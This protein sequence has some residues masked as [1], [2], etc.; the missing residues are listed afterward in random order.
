MSKQLK[1]QKRDGKG[2]IL[3]ENEDQLKDGRYR[4]R[5]IDSSNVRR[6]V[7]SWKLVPTDKTPKG[8]RDDISLREKE[9]EIRQDLDDGIRI[10]EATMSVGA[11]ITRY[12]DSKPK[13]AYRTKTNYI[14]MF[15][16]NI[17]PYFRGRIVKDIRKSDILRYYAYLYKERKFSATTIQLYQNL[18]FPAFQMAV[19]DDIIRKNPCKGCMKDYAQGSM[20]SNRIPLTRGEQEELLQWVKSDKC[21]NTYYSILAFL[22]GTGC[23]ISE[24]VGMT[25]DD[26]DFQNKQISVNHQIIYGKKNGKHQFY[27]STPKNG[28][29]RIVPI[30]DDLLLILKRHKAETYLLSR[31]S[32]FEV[33]GYRNF[34]FINSGLKTHMQNTLVRA[35]HGIVER[36]NELAF[37][38]D[39]PVLL[40]DFSPHTLRHTYCTRMAEN[41]IDVKVLQDIM[42]HKNI[43]VTMQVYNHCDTER[44]HEAINKI[45]SALEQCVC[46]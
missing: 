5:Y 22:L 6:A 10:V 2:R 37:E 12:L 40:P 16:K 38:E 1:Q 46:I 42:G 35:F 21:Y 43:S 32:E 24:A 27:A 20:T 39:N 25:W 11:L 17:E 44:L 31:T 26:I 18:I 13:L 15:Q 30:K 9:K 28:T 45:P 3:R 8:K 23:R 4:Y 33:E 29:S 34:V 7:Y 19:D 36:H 14:H 41:G